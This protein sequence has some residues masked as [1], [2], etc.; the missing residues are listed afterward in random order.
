MLTRRH[1]QINEDVKIYRPRQIYEGEK[2]LKYVE[3]SKRGEINGM[4]FNDRDIL[5]SSYGK[6]RRLISFLH[7]KETGIIVEEDKIEYQIP[8]TVPYTKKEENK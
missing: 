1:E 2:N 3:I 6:Q 5:T 7:M 4:E 8:K